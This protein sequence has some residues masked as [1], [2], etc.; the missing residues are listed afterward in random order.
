MVLIRPG[1]GTERSGEL[2]AVL[3]RMA[4][5]KLI[6]EIGAGDSTIYLANALQQARLDWKFDKKL[7]EESTW[8]ERSALV[9]PSG[10]PNEYRPRLI[11]IDDFSGEG[12]SAKDAWHDL[13]QRG[14]HERH[15]TFVEEEFFSIDPEIMDSW[16]SIDLAWIDA[17]TPAEDVRFV[18]ALWER[19]SPGGYLCLHEPMMV[20]TVSV[21]GALRVRN[22]RT[23][24][25]EEILSR[26]DC[27]FEALTLPE[28]HKYRQ[29]GL[30]IVRKRSATERIVRKHSLQAELLELGEIPIRSDFLK[31]GSVAPDIVA[32][33]TEFF[34]QMLFS[35][36]RRKVY[37]AIVLGHK[38]I[39]DISLETKLDLRT[40]N[41][42]LK[43]L[44]EGRLIQEGSDG[45]HEVEFSSSDCHFNS[46]REKLNLSDRQLESAAVVGSISNAFRKGV[47]Y[48][49]KDVSNICN[50]FTHDFARLRRHLVD[51]GILERRSGTYRRV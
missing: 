17:G 1:M 10:I 34:A 4:R 11:T 3:V 32:R 37:A 9:D 44:T 16:G 49:E 7:I 25:W 18:S 23:P 27:S 6:V 41:K 30:G 48:S 14:V 43:H 50:L 5:P 40:I 26:L 8:Q 42:E 33:K 15:V 31:M 19:I 13:R 20:T 24:I 21:D 38:N 35:P 12:S 2:L 46:R 29:N 39:E 47:F 45:F 51:K 22:V 28:F 36:S